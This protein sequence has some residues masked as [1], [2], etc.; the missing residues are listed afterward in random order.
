MWINSYITIR[1]ISVIQFSDLKFLVSPLCGNTYFICGNNTLHCIPWAW[2]CDND[3]EC[4]DGSDE[5]F[6]MC[7]NSGICG[8]NFTTPSGL[9][10]S[11]AYPNKH[12]E[13][14][15]CI[16]TI[17]QPLGSFINISILLFDISIKYQQNDYLEIRDG[18]SELSPLIGKFYGNNIPAFILT[19]QNHMWMK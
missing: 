18:N 3:T 13:S 17:T 11:P 19:T 4:I 16:Y 9:L 6:N 15:E 2:V 14:A 10:T 1:V 5:S 12:P 8:G 7:Q